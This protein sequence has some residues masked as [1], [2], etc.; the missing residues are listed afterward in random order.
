M[1]EVFNHEQ[2][3]PEWFEARRGIPTASKFSAILAKGSGK[4]RFRYM[5]QLAEEILSGKIA[6]GF[7]SEH[8]D[9]GK[10]LEDEAREWY[11]S[12]SNEEVSLVG[13]VKS[14]RK[15][16]SPDALVGEKGGLEIKTA[17]PHIQ[18]E[19]LKK[20]GLPNEYKAQVNGNIL[21]LEREWWDFISYPVNYP[22]LP[23]LKIRTFRDEGYLNMLSD[24]ID[25]F[26]LELDEMVQDIETHYLSADD[27]R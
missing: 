6:E 13:F 14:G 20:G 2:G 17:L 4:T 23:V 25:I 18:L 3:S 27:R 19:R 7:S 8:T 16:A 21:V 10:V 5:H 11:K 22:K 15:G 1:I 24:E 12:I 9:R 26:N